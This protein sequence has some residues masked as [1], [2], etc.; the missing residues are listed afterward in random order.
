[1]KDITIDASSSLTIISGGGL[2]ASGTLTQ[3][4]VLNIQ[5][6][7]SLIISGGNSI[8]LS[9]FQDGTGTDNQTL[10]LNGSSLSISGGNT[11]DLSSFGN[12]WE[13]FISKVLS[14]VKLFF[15]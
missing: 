3:N 10:S 1:M 9:A 6:G 8:N 13:I 11:I 4:G 5:S 14:L 15:S 7:G 12:K 2:T